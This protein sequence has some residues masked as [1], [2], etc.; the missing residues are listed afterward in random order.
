MSHRQVL[1]NQIM[2][3]N[4]DLAELHDGLLC[5]AIK[6]GFSK[7][8]VSK[9]VINNRRIRVDIKLYYKLHS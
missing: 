5:T 4:D 8:V 6:R 1:E 9:E 2:S 7:Y 3:H